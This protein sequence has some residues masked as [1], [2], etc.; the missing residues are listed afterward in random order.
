MRLRR[1]WGV[2][3]KVEYRG[4]RPASR[5]VMTLKGR[6]FELALKRRELESGPEVYRAC[7]AL[8]QATSWLYW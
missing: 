6:A 2:S 3:S 4:L 1:G 7:D 8:Q 5:R